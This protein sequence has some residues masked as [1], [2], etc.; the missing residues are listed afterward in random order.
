MGIGQGLDQKASR[1]LRR[2]YLR[3]SRDVVRDRLAA[4]MSGCATREHYEDLLAFLDDN[5]LGESRTYFV[6]AVNRIGN[7]V[8]PGRGRTAVESYA[9]DPVLGREASAV[10]AGR[11]RNS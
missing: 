11:G 7:R 8:S 3:T 1:E 6:H 5:Q 2:L 4:A 10:L 9:S